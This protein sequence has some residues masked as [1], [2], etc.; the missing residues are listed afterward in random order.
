MGTNGLSEQQP[1]RPRPR[2]RGRPTRLTPMLADALV[3][4]VRQTGFI[5]PAAERCGLPDAVVQEWV[6]RGTSAHP[7]RPGTR[8][9][10]D[11]AARIARAQGEWQAHLLDV[12]ATAAATKPDTWGAATWLLERFDRETYGRRERIDM[13]GMI[14]LEE[15]RGMLVAVVDLVQRYVPQARQEAE[16]ANFIATAQEAGAQLALPD[17]TRT[18]ALHPTGRTP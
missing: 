1:E 6:R 14:S 5:K 13:S 17:G 16:F 8:P 4:A 10:A 11:F 12:I 15:A 2:P 9:Y 3:A 7:T 18:I